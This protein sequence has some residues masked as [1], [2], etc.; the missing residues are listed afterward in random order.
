MTIIRGLKALSHGYTR[1]FKEVSDTEENISG[2]IILESV[3]ND[4]IIQIDNLWPQTIMLK[5]SISAV[6]ILSQSTI[7]RIENKHSFAPV[8]V[9]QSPKIDSKS[10]VQSSNMCCSQINVS[11]ENTGVAYGIDESN[12]TFAGTKF[13]HFSLIFEQKQLFEKKFI[14]LT[15][16]VTEDYS[17]G[18]HFKFYPYGGFF[19]Y[20][21]H[22]RQM[23][24]CVFRTVQDGRSVALRI[25]PISE[26]L[27]AGIVG[28]TG[29]NPIVGIDTYS[30]SQT[31][32]LYDE[33]KH[34]S[35]KIK[36]KDELS[37]ETAVY[38]SNTVSHI[39]NTN[40][41]NIY[42]IKEQK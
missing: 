12:I 36:V 19:K 23:E 10:I 18:S 4:P 31:L 24:L 25:S 38:L 8:N 40:L 9:Y 2:S 41:M 29:S 20:G 34:G 22:P 3:E 13:D 21:A 26:L 28:E 11:F 33:L 6:P 35:C 39:S 14:T 32:S 42:F 30:D 7:Q 17:V 5:A 15:E 37:G 27:N 1:N 16:S